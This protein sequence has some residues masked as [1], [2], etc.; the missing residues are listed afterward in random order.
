MGE[1]DY[2]YLGEESRECS[3]DTFCS[4]SLS[5][6]QVKLSGQFDEEASGSGEMADLE[7]GI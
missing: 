4:R 5:D 1:A 3:F 7:I 6:M 2:C